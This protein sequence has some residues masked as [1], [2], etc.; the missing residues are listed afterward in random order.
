MFQGSY[1]ALI[2]PFNENGVDYDAYKK[3]I[4]AQIAA[5]TDG[6]VPSGT[7]GESPTLTHEEHDE[8]I[9][10]CVKVVAGRIKVMAGTGSNATREA[11]E[12]T[13]HAQRVGADAAL[14]MTPYYNKPTQEGMYQH[15]KAIHDATNIAIFLYNIPGRSVVDLTDETIA[16]LM[17]LPRIV[18]IKDATGDL[19]RPERLA[20]IDPE[21]IQFSGEDG[22][23]VAFNRLGGTGCISVSANVIPEICAKM[24]A[25]C[26]QAKWDEAEKLQDHYADLHD[27]MFCEPSPQ[28]AKY[29]LNVLGQC[30]NRLRLPLI[31]VSKES[32]ER[33]SGVLAALELKA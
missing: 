31:A 1:T 14:I 3:L 12:R 4:E 29:A 9:A 26:L 5:G 10:F 18:G 19:S 15:Y 33:I 21:F 11:I 17:K 7:T 25:L 20:K 2:T 27:V 23:A 22:T 30:E 28:P 13:Q 32:E 8:V 16:R 6:V 24:Q